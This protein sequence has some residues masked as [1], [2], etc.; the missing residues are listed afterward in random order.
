M[1]KG[2]FARRY[3]TW[4]GLAPNSVGLLAVNTAED[5]LAGLAELCVATVANICQRIVCEV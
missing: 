5:Y 1:L 3:Q 2:G 4:S